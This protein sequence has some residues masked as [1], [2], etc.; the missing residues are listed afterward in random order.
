MSSARTEDRYDAHAGG[1][2]EFAHRNPPCD[3]D[4]GD[5]SEWN[6]VDHPFH[7][8]EE[9]LRQFPKSGA[10]ILVTKKSIPATSLSQVK[11]LSP[12]SDTQLLAPHSRTTN[13]THLLRD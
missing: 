1:E 9:D 6:E 4:A 8:Y 12:W 13:A 7:S 2:Q 11:T 5:D 3:F 10:D